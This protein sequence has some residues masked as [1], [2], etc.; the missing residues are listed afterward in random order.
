MSK[1]TRGVVGLVAL[2]GLSLFLLNCGST[3]NRS[4][5]LLYVLSQG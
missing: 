2:C 5:G 3:V 4:S 1:K